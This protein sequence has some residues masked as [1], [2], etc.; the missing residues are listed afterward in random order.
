VG[1]LGVSYGASVGLVTA[2]RD[3]R[4]AAVVAFQPFASAERA[5]PELMRAAFPNE[6]RGITDRQFAAAHLKEAAW[7]NFSWSSADIPAALKRTQ[8]PVLFIH[9]EKD[10]WITPDHSR[11]LVK[12]APSGSK[13]LLAPLDDHL[14]LP[15]QLDTFAPEVIDWFEAS[16][17]KH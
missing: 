8:A 14:S 6:A 2:G 12:L 16:L 1:L 13:L 15:L 10:T 5:V 7:A 4:I 3:R 9:G 11:E 17:P